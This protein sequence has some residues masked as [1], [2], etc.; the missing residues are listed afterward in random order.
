MDPF[1]VFLAFV[2]CDTN[3]Y[4]QYK[5]SPKIVAFLNTQCKIATI[6]GDFLYH[7]VYLHMVEYVCLLHWY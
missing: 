2:P 3:K 4:H 7:P 6:F 1:G 5:K